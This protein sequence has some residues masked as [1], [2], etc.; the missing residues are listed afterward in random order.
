MQDL[1]CKAA[2][3]LWTRCCTTCGGMATCGLRPHP[4]RTSRFTERAAGIDRLRWRLGPREVALAAVWRI[5]SLTHTTMSQ[6]TEKQF[7]QHRTLIHMRVHGRRA[8]RRTCE[9][10]SSTHSCIVRGRAARA[11]HQTPSSTRRACPRHAHLEWIC[12]G[13]THM[14]RV[15]P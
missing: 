2:C 15:C 10:Y 3:S 13:Q 5:I 4:S 14:R 11:E 8:H 1:S 9:L 7:A 6:R 12:P